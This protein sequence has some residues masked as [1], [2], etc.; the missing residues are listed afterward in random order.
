MSK[1]YDHKLKYRTFDQLINA[2]ADDF[3]GHDAESLIDPSQLI[4]VVRKVNKQLGLRITRTREVMLDFDNFVVN[5]PDDLENINFAV[6]CSYYKTVVPAIQGTQTENVDTTCSACCDS[7]YVTECGDTYQIAQ[8]VLPNLEYVF[9]ITKRVNI[10]HSL[11]QIDPEEIAA[12]ILNDNFM[13]MTLKYGK[14]Y[15]NY[16]GMLQDEKGNLMVL[17]HPMVNDYYEYSIK[18][19]ILENMYFQGEDTERKLA[20]IMPKLQ[21]AKREAYNVTNMPEFKELQEV[22]DLNREAMYKKYYSIFI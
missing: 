4:R 14:L 17:D 15:L 19:R 18:E 8:R 11:Y 20:Y 12:V 7:V 10:K 2:V 22:N 9:N 13:R 6:L 21:I 5:L 16:E 3:Y 1:F